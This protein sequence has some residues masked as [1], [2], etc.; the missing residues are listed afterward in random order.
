MFT[1]NNQSYN[2]GGVALYIN[3]S[4]PVRVRPVQTIAIADQCKWH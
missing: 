2:K 3:N 1:S 4:I